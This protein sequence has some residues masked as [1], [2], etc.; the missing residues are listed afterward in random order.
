MKTR[1]I[2]V[3]CVPIG[4][5]APV[6]VQSMTNTDTKNV[7][8]T[9]AQILELEKAHCDIVRCAVYDEDCAKYIP[10]IKEQIHIPLVADVHFSSDIAIAA[11]ENGADKL[12]INPGNIGGEQEILRVVDAAKAHHI[13]IRVGANGGS[14]PKEYIE[15]YGGRNADAL[16]ECA[17]DNIRVLEQAHFHDIVVSIKSSSVPV[18][19]QAYR[20]ISKIVDYPLHLGVTEAGTYRNAVMKSAV[21]LGALLLDGIGETIRV[22]ITGD[23]VQEV[24]AGRDILKSCGFMTGGVEIISCPTCARCTLDIEKIVQSIETFTQDMSKPLKVAIMGCAVNGPGEAKEADVGIAGGKGEALL[25]ERGKILRKVD[26]FDIVPELK[27]MILE[28]MEAER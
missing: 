20:K 1:Q 25:F 18:C 23:P 27:R 15:V 14:L 4:G 8:A 10:K 5:G 19:V 24:H 3:G 13:P 26:E 7:R 11:I 28:W 9:V 12:R 17:L 16:V 22:S 6:C 21:A 2:N